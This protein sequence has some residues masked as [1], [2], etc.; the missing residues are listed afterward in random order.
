MKKIFTFFAT[1]LLT[2]IVFAQAPQKMS[3]QAVIRDGGNNLV[4]SHLV[5]M[6]ISILQ[7]SPGGTA[8][9]TETV[10]PIPSTNANGLV[11]IEIGS[12][13]SF[14]SI[15]WSNGPYYIKTETD[16]LGG[17]AY[18]ITGT[19]QIL[20]VPYALY[21]K[22]SGSGTA[23]GTTNYL[24]KFTG[25][26]T[27][28]NSMMFDDGTHVGIGTITPTS[29]FHISSL[30]SVSSSPSTSYD[31]PFKIIQG[32]FGLL[33]DGNEIQ[34]VGSGG[35]LY[36]N[37]WNSD[38]ILMAYGGGKIGVGTFNPA[39]R[40]DIV[41]NS[42][43]SNPQLRLY[44]NESDYARMSFASNQ[45]SSYYSIAG[46][47]MPTDIDSK[48]NFYFS[49]YGDIMTLNGRGNILAGANS[50]IHTGWWGYNNNHLAK[51]SVLSHTPIAGYF[52]SDSSDT[53]GYDFVPVIVSRY[54]GN[55]VT[56][57]VGIYAEALPDQVNLGGNGTGGM[58]FG[59]SYGIDAEAY[60]GNSDFPNYQ[61]GVYGVVTGSGTSNKYG[62]YGIT[63]GASS[64]YGVY[65]SGD[66]AY[67]GT[68]TG[69]SDEKFKENIE[70]FHGALDKVKQIETYTYTF[71]KDGEATLMQLSEG[72]QIGFISQQLEQVFPNLVRNDVNAIPDKKN[73]GKETVIKY[74][75]VN[76]T[77]MIPV[78]T[79]AIKEQQQIIE[80]QAAAIEEL[81]AENKKI[82][83]ILESLQK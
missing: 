51:F 70:T 4:T 28:G 53:F 2:A 11:S 46:L 16:P 54:K 73:R 38:N 57:S 7:G 64:R 30:K 79:Q 19:S 25:S 45:T 12:G 48:L 43:V 27:L 81:K 42:T 76:Y 35:G 36:F 20:S 49:P 47:L 18:S 63:Y 65:C 78:L 17:V 58:F 61:Y 80:A 33:M 8:V 10:S 67:T 5:G 1:V 52:E 14:S 62:I 22:T 26:N 72:P 69:P 66:M 59:G 21:A 29:D 56:A 32:S 74:K 37:Y 9:Y 15:D 82:E 83:S 39:A 31:V 75:G 71:K 44:E 60:S 68:L 3:Y 77:G 40:L 24:A 41:H 6:K 23:T 34:S 55:K 50:D 13:G